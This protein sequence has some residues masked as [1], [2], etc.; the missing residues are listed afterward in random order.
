MIVLDDVSPP[1]HEIARVAKTLAEL[2]IHQMVVIEHL[3][4][5]AWVRDKFVSDLLHEHMHGSPEVMLQEA[6]LLGID[7]RVPR[8]VALIDITSIVESR[9]R[10]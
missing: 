7:L 8:S 1:G 9:L 2:I 10:R 6:A 3:P 4:Q 5:Q